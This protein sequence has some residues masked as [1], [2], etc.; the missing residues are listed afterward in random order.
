MIAPCAITMSLFAVNFLNAGF[1][2]SKCTSA[3]CYRFTENIIIETVIIAELKF[4]D[5]QRH[6]LFAD[7]VECAHNSALHNRPKALNRVGVNR[8][9]DVFMRGVADDAMR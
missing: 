6:V 7:L 2:R 5:I 1:W 8:T 9:D 3:A 4:R